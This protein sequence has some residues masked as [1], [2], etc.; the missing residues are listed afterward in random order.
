MNRENRIPEL[1]GDGRLLDT[2]S[3]AEYLG[4]S[5][6]WLRCSRM[7]KAPWNGP[8]PVKFGKRAVR[9]RLRD[10]N[11]FVNQHRVV[12]DNKQVATA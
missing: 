4:V 11:D 9:Y 12:D 1:Y 8:V 10:L 7:K 5:A 6:Q 2:K 3:A